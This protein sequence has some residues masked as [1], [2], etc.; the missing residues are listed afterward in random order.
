[1]TMTSLPSQVKSNKRSFCDFCGPKRPAQM[2][3]P[4]TGLVLCYDC[5]ED[6]SPAEKACKTKLLGIVPTEIDAPKGGGR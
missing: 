6:R 4:D 2:T 3:E 5:H 1:M